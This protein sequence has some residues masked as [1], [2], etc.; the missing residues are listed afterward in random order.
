VAHFDRAIP[1][2]G[3]GKVTMTV[4]LTHYQGPVW[5]SAVV[6]SNDPRHPSVSINLQ[7]KVI[8]H[9]EIRPGPMVRFGPGKTEG[10]EKTLEFISLD[11][12]FQVLK[13]ENSLGEKI[14]LQLEP[15]IKE[16]QYRV[17]IRNV[18]ANQGYAGTVRF[19]TSHPQKPSLEIWIQAIP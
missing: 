16:K 17:T 5:K 12:P 11:L 9:I 3:E 13:I 2:G 14:S 4:D 7:G 15:L 1:P 6:Y 19:L 8:P 18:A 10:Q